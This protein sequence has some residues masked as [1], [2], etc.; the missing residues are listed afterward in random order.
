MAG[1]AAQPAVGRPP[2][3]SMPSSHRH[4]AVVILVAEDDLGDQILIREALQ[5]SPASK[6]I[7]IVGDGEEALE[8]LYRS[9]RYAAPDAKPI[10]DLILLDLNMPR[11]GGKEVL[12]RLKT[13]VE[14]KTIPIVVFTTSGRDE[15]VLQCY[16][17]GVNS[18][19]QK[20]AD[21]DQFQTT[22]HN[23]QHYWIEVGIF[24]PRPRTAR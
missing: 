24:P 14:R 17:L 22:M 12:A 11:L 4:P 3:Y 7:F 8:Y 15:D 1:V 20:P 18:Y 16:A 10:P 9:G 13:D 19:V 23:L 6:E 2:L 5:A 21:F